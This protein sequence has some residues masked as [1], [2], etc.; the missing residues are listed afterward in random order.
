[1]SASTASGTP[2]RIVATGAVGFDQLTLAQDRPQCEPRRRQLQLSGLRVPV[3]Y[4]GT[5]LESTPLEAKVANGTVSLRLAVAFGSAPV[6][7]LKDIKVKG[8]EL[9]PILVDFL[10]QAYAVTGPMDLTGEASLR[11][12]DPWRT[13]NGSGRL[14]IGPGKVMGKDV[15]NLVN[16][17]VGLAGAASALLSP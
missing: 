10:C 12:T 14:R 3:A 7:T 11:A 8:V 17:V 1:V 15:V 13:A 16:Q 5:Q 4:A 6:A 2:A 9:G